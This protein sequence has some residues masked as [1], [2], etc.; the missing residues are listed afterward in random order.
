LAR[1]FVKL[2]LQDGTTVGVG[3]FQ[4]GSDF[5]FTG[6]QPGIKLVQCEGDDRFGRN[7][8]GPVH[9]HKCLRIG[10]LDFFGFFRFQPAK[11][12]INRR[13]NKTNNC[14]TAND[15]GNDFAERSL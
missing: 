5:G 10:D 7:H 1:Q 3:I 2:V 12:F 11:G 15:K 6:I 8:A 4:F 9:L 13:E 14:D